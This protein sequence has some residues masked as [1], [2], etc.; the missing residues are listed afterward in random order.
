[1][2]GPLASGYCSGMCGKCSC[3]LCWGCE[4]CTCTSCLPGQVSIAK[5]GWGM[6]HICGCKCCYIPASSCCTGCDCGY[7]ALA[8]A[9]AKASAFLAALAMMA[10]RQVEADGTYQILL[11]LSLF[12]TIMTAVLFTVGFRRTPS[13]GHG[14][15]LKQPLVHEG[16]D[17]VPDV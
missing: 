11:T 4:G 15:T 13:A 16:T 8:P 6:P 7:V 10:A 1:M 17:A 3:E 12:L 5:G 14:G 2:G 9:K